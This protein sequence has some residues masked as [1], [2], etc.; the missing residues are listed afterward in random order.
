[1]FAKICVSGANNLVKISK[2][3]SRNAGFFHK[4]EVG[5]LEPEKDLKRWIS[6]SNIWP[7]MRGLE[8]GTS[9][10]HLPM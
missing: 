4:M 6:G 2:I 10:Y 7:K 8:D 1:M 5:S 3:G 9:T